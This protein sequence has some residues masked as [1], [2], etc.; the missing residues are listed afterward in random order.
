[1]PSLDLSQYSE[2]HARRLDWFWGRAG[3][4]TGYPAPLD[5]GS[6]LVSRPKGIYKPKDLDCALSIRINLDSPYKDGEIFTRDDGTW[7]FA[8]HQEN[9]NPEQRD[10]EYTNRGLLEC[11]AKRIPVGVLRERIPDASNKDTYEVLGL[12]I[13]TGWI[14]GYFM[15]EGLRPDGYSHRDGT[16]IEAVISAAESETSAPADAEPPEDD[17]DARIRVAR[18]IVAR[19]GQTAFRARLLNAYRGRCAV[20][21]TTAEPVL[22]AAHIR[23]YRGPASN[24]VTNGLLLRAD[25]HTL[26]DLQLLAVFPATREIVVSKRLGDTEY[27]AFSGAP[28]EQPA[29]PS[30]R[31]ATSAL[32]SS[33]IRFVDSEGHT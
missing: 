24:T 8:Y 14:D 29:S 32:E 30:N 27:A 9:A 21:G 1:M 6:F 33:W 17:Y 19:R 5:D 15:F 26:F 25:V 10:K 18:S 16:A 13:P 7:Y 20:T 11:I 23:P 4:T 12:A 28:L 31:P 3:L 22:E 2:T